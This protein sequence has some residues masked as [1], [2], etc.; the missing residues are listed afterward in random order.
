MKRELFYKKAFNQHFL[1]S[2]LNYNNLYNLKQINQCKLCILH[3]SKKANYILANTK[4]KIFIITKKQLAAKEILFLEKYLEKVNIKKEEIFI[5]PIT[6]CDFSNDKE[7]II[8][9]LPYT[10]NELIYFDIKKVLLLDKDLLEYF[11]LSKKNFCC[12]NILFLN[13]KIIEVI[14]SFS[15]EYLQKNPNKIEIF[16]QSLKLLMEK[17]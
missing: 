6:K 1:K 5:S 2:N 15:I 13:G 11:N 12:K 17:E 14:T 16:E 8:K 4:T 10:I 7:N 9:C 3:K